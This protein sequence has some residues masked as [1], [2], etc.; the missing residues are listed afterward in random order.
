MDCFSPCQLWWLEIALQHTG[1]QKD[2][3]LCNIA[4][5]L[6][7]PIGFYHANL[8]AAMFRRSEKYTHTHTHTHTHTRTHARTHARTHTHTHTHTHAHKIKQAF[9]LLA[10]LGWPVC[11]GSVWLRDRDCYSSVS[12]AVAVFISCLSILLVFVH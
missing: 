4:Y 7:I 12:E 3:L 9:H 6:H 8:G 10:A 1:K 5:N 2:R 11:I